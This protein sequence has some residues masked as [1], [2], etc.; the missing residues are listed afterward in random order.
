MLHRD[1]GRRPILGVRGFVIAP[2][3]ESVVVVVVVV[4]AF[5]LSPQGPSSRIFECRVALYGAESVGYRGRVE[6]GRPS[7]ERSRRRESVRMRTGEGETETDETRGDAVRD[8]ETRR[9]GDEMRY[10]RASKKNRR[11]DEPGVLKDKG[12]TRRGD[13]RPGYE[14]LGSL[15]QGEY[16]RRRSMATLRDAG[17]RPKRPKIDDFGAR[18]RANLTA[19]SDVEVAAMGLRAARRR[20]SEHARPTIVDRWWERNVSHLEICVGS[21]QNLLNDRI[22]I[23]VISPISESRYTLQGHLKPTSSCHWS[24]GGPLLKDLGG[25]MVGMLTPRVLQCQ[26]VFSARLYSIMG[27]TQLFLRTRKC[28]HLYVLSTLCPHFESSSISHPFVATALTIFGMGTIIAH[29]YDPGSNVRKKWD[30]NESEESRR[31]PPQNTGVANDWSLFC[32]E[33][34]HSRFVLRFGKHQHCDGTRKGVMQDFDATLIKGELRTLVDMKKRFM[35]RAEF[36]GCEASRGIAQASAGREMSYMGPRLSRTRRCQK[37]KAARK[38][39]DV[40]RGNRVGWL[41]V[42]GNG[43]ARFGAMNR[44]KGK[45][46]REGKRPGEVGGQVLRERRKAAERGNAALRKRRRAQ[47]GAGEWAQGL[48]ERGRIGRISILRQTRS[49]GGVAENSGQDSGLPNLVQSS[50]KMSRQLTQIH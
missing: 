48:G 41:Q 3:S 43:R 23:P 5:L 25:T 11:C 44:G 49:A 9:D 14:G 46:K 31:G 38:C 16:G 13:A 19:R 45:L 35:E 1:H 15:L 27:T 28:Q 10:E 30:R 39:G 34:W 17:P 18:A 26:R 2:S 37:A 6:L 7:P 42:V 8:G 22:L 21:V 24:N 50:D 33:R 40:G 47:E 12:D 32:H 4:A 36:G 29:L 20:H